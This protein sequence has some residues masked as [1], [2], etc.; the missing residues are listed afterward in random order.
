MPNCSPEHV[1]R[2]VDLE[3][4]FRRITLLLYDTSV[5]LPVLEQEVIPYLDSNIEFIDGLISARGRDKFQLGLRGFHC[6]IYFDFD[7]FQLDVK[8]NSS[9]QSGRVMVDG[10]MNLRQIPFY[11]YPLRT[12]L[13]YDF[14]FAPDGRSFLIT[15]LEEIWSVGDLFEN[16]PF[17]GRLY[18]KAR[19]LAGYLFMGFSWLASAK[20]RGQAVTSRRGA[21]GRRPAR[22]LQD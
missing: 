2:T 10:V 5:S 9:G 16:A 11:T 17:V 14:V 1:L 19:A 7:I 6:A 18:Q 22:Y 15:R 20:S 4:H 3:E 8:M 13:V 12:I 21:V